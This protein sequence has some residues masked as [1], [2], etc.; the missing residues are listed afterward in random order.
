M[1]R[2]IAATGGATSNGPA[3][4]TL[5]PDETVPER[6]L[7]ERPGPELVGQP[8]LLHEFTEALIEASGEPWAVRAF[9]QSRADGT[10]LGWLAF[11]DLEGRTVRRT[12]RETTQSTREQVAY[13]ASGLQGSY[14][15]GAFQRATSAAGRA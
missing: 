6:A 9:G 8:E 10:W 5:V 12:P 3:H 7:A 15:E 2:L 4:L 14:L 1:R 11:V 13:W